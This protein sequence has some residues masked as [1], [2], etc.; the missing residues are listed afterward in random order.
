M[1]FGVGIDL[2]ELKQ[3]QKVVDRREEA[4]LQK[5]FTERELKYSK[6]KNFIQSL[7][8]RWA[9][10][11]AFLKA[12]GTGIQNMRALKEIEIIN[13][14]GGKPYINLTGELKTKCTVLN[15][16]IDASISHSKDYATGMV[17]LSRDKSF[18]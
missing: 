6:Q 9:V 17:V 2:Q 7:A 13:L 3:F 4:F 11:E 18:G 12:M 14:H 5:V 1:I 16:K 8:G 10:K 15:I